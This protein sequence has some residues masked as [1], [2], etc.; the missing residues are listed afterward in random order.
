M[1]LQGPPPQKRA[2][3]IDEL[4]ILAAHLG[5]PGQTQGIGHPSNGPLEHELFS[6]IDVHCGGFFPW[7]PVVASKRNVGGKAMIGVR[8]A[9]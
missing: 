9:T 6:R 1:A 3:P 2:N 7:L 8:G 5:P 4:W